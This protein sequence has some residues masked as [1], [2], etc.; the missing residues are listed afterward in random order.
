MA[1]NEMDDEALRA[2]AEG[3]GMQENGHGYAWRF[4]RFHWGAPG[5]GEHTIRSRAFDVRGDVQP[6][7]DDPFLA[8]KKLLGE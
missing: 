4:W 7:L 3:H 5:R 6:A 8:S 1:N 2:G